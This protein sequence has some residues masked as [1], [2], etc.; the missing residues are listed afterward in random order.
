MVEDGVW[1]VHARRGDLR[2]LASEEY[3]ASSY[4]SLIDAQSASL[5]RTAALES[6]DWM[7]MLSPFYFFSGF[8]S[9]S[10]STSG[11]SLDFGFGR[12][13]LGRS[14]CDSAHGGRGAIRSS[15]SGLFRFINL[16]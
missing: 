15:A 13:S 3:T 8:F 2:P 5:R 11:A 7:W 4:G 9:F 14:A 1:R 12:V 16:I 6:L 10:I